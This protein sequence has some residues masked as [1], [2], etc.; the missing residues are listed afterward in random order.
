MIILRGFIY[1]GKFTS[2]S[3]Y[4]KFCYVEEIVTNKSLFEDKMRKFFENSVKN[5][6]KAENYV[7][8]F[9]IT[10]NSDVIVVEIN[11]FVSSVNILLS[12]FKK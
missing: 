11:P 8:D 2:L 3:H 12:F 1:N 4:Y 10:K 6:I 5:R 9:A 7:C